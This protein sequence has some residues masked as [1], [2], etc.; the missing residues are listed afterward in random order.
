MSYHER[1]TLF[2]IK[3]SLRVA[4]GL[5]LAGLDLMFSCSIFFYFV[6]NLKKFDFDN[7]EQ[8]NY[9]YIPTYISALI[10]VALIILGC[11]L[12]YR[13]KGDDYSRASINIV[14]KIFLLSWT[15]L[16][17]LS[18]IF[19]AIRYSTVGFDPNSASY[20]YY[21]GNG[22]VHIMVLL[23]Y[24]CAVL[25]QK[26]KENNQNKD[27]HGLQNVMDLPYPWENA[28]P[29]YKWENVEWEKRY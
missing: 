17:I 11:L 20:Q 25:H 16:T 29:S 4:F 13:A 22:I 24:R 5:F 2:C 1:Y 6:V 3:N 9:H 15:T 14:F 26:P 18:I 7:Q 21:V 27:C 23:V 12:T 28:T 8:P 19:T 10:S